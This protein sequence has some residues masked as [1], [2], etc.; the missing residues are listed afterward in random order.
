MGN[1]IREK[2]LE[3]GTK[4]TQRLWEPSDGMGPQVWCPDKSCVFCNNCTNVL[5]DYTNGP[6]MFFCE[7][8]IDKDGVM[9]VE[10]MG[11]IYGK[12][13]SFEPKEG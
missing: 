11:G 6:Y 12:C 8:A 5:F 3:D 4:I 13:E 10:K 9:D 1:N 2:T 7:K